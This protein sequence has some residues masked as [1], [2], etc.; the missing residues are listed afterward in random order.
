L[1]I[2]TLIAILE[3]LSKISSQMLFNF[4]DFTRLYLYFKF[5]ALSLKLEYTECK[6]KI[7]LKCN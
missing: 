4:Y 7:I 5:K 2:Y 3:L 6:L 1:F